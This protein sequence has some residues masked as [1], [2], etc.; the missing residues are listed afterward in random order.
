MVV[1]EK[2]KT[3]DISNRFVQDEITVSKTVRRIGR[4]LI[5]ETSDRPEGRGSADSIR[6]KD[7]ISLVINQLLEDGKY[8]K[9]ALMVFG[10]NT[11]FRTGDMLS[12]RVKDLYD[13][14][15]MTCKNSI[16]ISEDKTGKSRM[17]YLNQA[18]QLMLNLLMRVK[19][20]SADNYVFRS[21]GN[22][23]AY[24]LLIERDADGN[25][26]EVRTTG[27]RYDENGN[28]REVAPTTV[29]TTSRWLKETFGQVYPEL[30][31]S[32]YTFRQSYAYWLS[33]GWNEERYSAC[34]T[35]DFGHS[36]RALTEKHY[37]GVTKSELKNK[38]LSMN[39]GLEGILMYL[40]D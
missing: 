21:E 14:E 12:L 8:F 22:R 35:A 11:G 3:F 4:N 39:L 36:S 27:E 37:M 5:A 16:T 26:V 10:F 6:D 15:T 33:K 31:I 40:G 38:Q 7:I 24:L 23:K 32:S 9:A 25:V 20:L 28:K 18:V 1:A 13:L 2:C 29:M 30:Q 34:V 19:T 17:V